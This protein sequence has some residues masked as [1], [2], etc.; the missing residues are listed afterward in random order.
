[1][2]IDVIPNRQSRSA[3]LLRESYREGQK[4]RKRTLANLSRWKPERVEVLRRLLAGEWDEAVLS[5]PVCGLVFGV[6]YALKQLADQ[7]GIAAALGRRPLGKLALFLVLAR[8]AHQRSRLSAVRWAQGQAVEEVLGT[9]QFDEDDLYEVLDEVAGRQQEI[10]QT[11]YRHYRQR[12]GQAPTLFLYDVTSSY[13]EGENNELGEYGHNRDGKRG[14]LQIVIG[15]LTDAS[16][17]PLAVRVFSGNTS[18]PKTVAEQIEILKT[19]FHVDTDVVFVGDRGMVKSPGKQAL[20]DAHLRYITALTDPQI[21]KLLK[22]GR[23]QLGL[24]EETVCEVEADQVRYLLR[25]NLEQA[26]K[27]QYRLEDKMKKL[28]TLLEQRN[29]VVARSRRCRPEAGLRK[30]QRWVDTYKLAGVVKL[31]LQERMLHIEVDELAKERSQELAGC[32]VLETDVPKASLDAETIHQRYKDLAQV[33]QEFRNLKTGLLEVRPIFLQ[34][35][36]R[37]R[38]HVLICMIALKLSRELRRRL[39]AVYGTTDQ[40]RYA[41]TLKDALEALGRWCL[42]TYSLT[43]SQTVTRIPRPDAQQTEILKALQVSIPVS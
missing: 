42:L 9:D 36:E 21:R 18:D 7:L 41:T 26:R 6:L 25:K 2:F 13:L 35:E 39:T 37:T 11:L 43:D 24:F 23:L 1:M 19:H 27:D 10:E 34:K 8:V 17:E 32:Y 16:G 3:I 15:L 28:Q 14:K 29:Q 4:V 31:R 38:G 5:Q 30:L 12:Q 20:K 40:N 22:Q 33:E